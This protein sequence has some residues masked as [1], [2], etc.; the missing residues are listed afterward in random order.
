MLHFTVW[1]PDL[2]A[3]DGIVRLHEARARP[4]DSFL[5]SLCGLSTASSMAHRV[6]GVL[7]GYPIATPSLRIS[8]RVPRNQGRLAQTLMGPCARTDGRHGLPHPVE[9]AARTAGAGAPSTS[10]R[11]LRRGPRQ[12]QYGPFW[13][14]HATVT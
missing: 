14:D 2:A 13:R 1:H 8:T 7:V 10:R 12:K 9:P 4:G 5:L 6:D 11:K 3:A